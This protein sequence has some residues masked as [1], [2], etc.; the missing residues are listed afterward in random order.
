MNSQRLT[1]KVPNKHVP[2]EKTVRFK[3]VQQE[4]LQGE[5]QTSF[6]T[7]QHCQVSP[8]GGGGEMGVN[9]GTKSR[10]HIFKL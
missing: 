6:S 5:H 9:R 8:L 7:Q 1:H 2:Q 3:P 10:R 4:V